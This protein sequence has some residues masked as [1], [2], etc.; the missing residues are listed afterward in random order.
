MS[1]AAASLHI[2][3]ATQTGNAEFLAEQAARL[4]AASGVA[5]QLAELDRV[6]MQ[7]MQAMRRC[8][9]VI[10]TTGDGD[11]PDAALDFGAAL[12]APDA[13]DLGA[14]GFAVLG[15]GDT[16][17]DNF[18]QAGKTIDARLEVLGAARLAPRIDC[19]FDFEPPAHAWLRANLPRLTDGLERVGE[20]SA[21]VVVAGGDGSRW[22][23]EQPF[24]ARMTDMVRLSGKAS[25]KDVRHYAFGLAGSGLAYAPGD[26]I[27]LV[28]V[29]HMDL[30]RQLIRRLGAGPYDPVPGFDAPLLELLQRRFDI[31]A[32]SQSLIAFLAEQ[33]ADAELNRAYACREAGELS[34]FLWGHDIYDLLARDARLRIEPAVFLGLLQPLRHRTYSIASSP[35]TH[36]DEIHMTVATVRWQHRDRLHR[37]VASTWL[38]DGL[39]PGDRADVF[40]LPNPRFRLPKATDLPVIM[41]GPGTGVAPFR[42]FL[43]HRRAQGASGKNWLLFGDW[44][45]ESDFLYGE[46]FEALRRDGTLTRLD[47]AFSRD[48]SEKF[49]VQQRMLEHSAELYAWLQEGGHFYVC[50]DA[51]EMAVAVDAALHEVVR[52]AG[53]HS[54]AAAQD[55]VGALRRDGRYQRDV[56]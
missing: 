36:P 25:A 23:R 5:V 21:A 39:R 45:R 6:S 13:P 50:G 24:S 27:G 55:Y 22:S 7:E 33:G 4:C 48:Q 17:Y 53:G 2:L 47:L 8:L 40:V 52:A 20:G 19:D 51:E 42:A 26:G 41:V 49:Y 37:G 28:P 9:V 35:L 30:V 34:A 11:L 10:S 46:E 14:L 43:Q 44:N 12:F 18:C 38:A 16:A 56:Y 54:E 15:L 1:E 31:T 3:F 29:N 32:P